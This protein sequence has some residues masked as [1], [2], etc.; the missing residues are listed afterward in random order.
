MSN[1]TYLFGAGA[2]CNSMPLVRDFKKRLEDWKTYFGRNVVNNSSKTD[3]F[4]KRSESTVSSHYEGFL[5]DIEKLIS[6][7]GNHNSIDTYAKK[8]AT[9]E[10]HDDLHNLKTLITMFFMFEQK[11]NTPDI[12]YD[13]LIGN[14]RLIDPHVSF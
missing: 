1:V 10:R 2:S 4:F 7:L 11:V 14:F 5:K 13:S 6:N 12:R 3:E 8:L 9:L